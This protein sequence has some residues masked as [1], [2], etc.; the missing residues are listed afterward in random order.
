MKQLLL[1]ALLPALLVALSF[2]VIAQAD[3]VASNAD[4]KTKCAGCHGPNG[5]GKPALK[6]APLSDSAKKSDA[7]LTETITKGKGKMPAYDGKLSKDQISG[8]VKS[9]KASAKK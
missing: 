2:P 4:Y 9:I 1:K 5:E 6:T 8:L 7:E 3:D